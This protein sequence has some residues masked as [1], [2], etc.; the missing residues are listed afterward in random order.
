[1][2]VRYGTGKRPVACKVSASRKD[3]V[4]LDEHRLERKSERR[5]IEW[6]ML[7]VNRPEST[8]ITNVLLVGVWGDTSKQGCGHELVE[9]VDSMRLCASVRDGGE[10]NKEEF[11]EHRI[12][13][14]LGERCVSL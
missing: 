1:M 10:Y 8:A 4:S 2:Y 9:E 12:K 13:L 7:V 6:G 3:V 14:L 11:R 5:S